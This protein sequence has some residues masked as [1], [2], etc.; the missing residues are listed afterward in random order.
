MIFSSEKWNDA[1][2]ITKYLQASAALSFEK[3][4]GALADAEERFLRKVLG[5]EML[6]RL[7]DIYGK[8]ET[9][10]SKAE[11]EVLDMSQKI[12]ANIAMWLNFDEFQIRLT[13][14]GIQRTES[15]NFK[16]AYRYQER[17]MKAVYRNRGLNAI[18]GLMNLLSAMNKDKEKGFPEFEKSEYRK[19]CM[20]RIVKDAFEVNEYYFI[21]NSPIVYLRLLPIFRRITDMELPKFFD[22]ELLRIMR[23]AMAVDGEFVHKGTNFRKAF[24]N[25]IIPKAL[26]E[27]VRHGGSIT[28]RGLY[29]FSY[30]NGRESDEKMEQASSRAVKGL[31]DHLEEDAASRRLQLDA[32]IQLAFPEY[33]HGAE[34]DVMKRD[35]N[36]KRTFWA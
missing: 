3:C 23:E 31:A 33:W 13:D 26:A 8:D 4:Q 15:D 16:Q 27:L 1:E 18:D 21:E 29:F 20:R 12:V 9:H 2:E 25:Y 11:Q 7:Q 28:D 34:S 30:T 5:D 17:N 36:H 35:N 32:L 10:R 19:D 24:G 14:Q 6:A 22:K